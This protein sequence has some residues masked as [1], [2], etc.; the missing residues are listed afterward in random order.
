MNYASRLKTISSALNGAGVDALLVTHL[1]NVRYLCGFTGSAGALVIY[2]AGHKPRPVFYTDGR[3]TQQAAEE[4]QGARV[5]IAKKPALTEAC[6][7]LGRTKAK[8]LGFE[9]N[10]LSYATYRQIRQ[11]LKNSVRLKP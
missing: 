1:P 11:V 5:V 2:T 7:A 6:A 8:V 10:Q 9:A 4:I 3:Y